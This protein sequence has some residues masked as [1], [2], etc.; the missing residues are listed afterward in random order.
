[1]N[2]RLVPLLWENTDTSR[3]NQYI[4]PEPGDEE[5]P[6]ALK[7]MARGEEGPA[8]LSFPQHNELHVIRHFTRLAG[9]NYSI[10]S[11]MYPLGSCTM[12][13]N[14]RINDAM[15]SRDEFAGIHPKNA[16]RA[17]GS[18]EILYNLQHLLQELSGFDAV[19]LN[20]AAGAQGELTGVMMI[21]KYHES[22]GDRA[23]RYVIV[24]DTAHGTNP[25]T[26]VM[27]GLEVK[28]VASDEAGQVDMEALKGMLGP[29]I[30]GM[31]LTNPN[32]LGI[33]EERVVEIC[34]LVHEAGGLM[35]G[36][37]ANFNAIA[38]IVKP[39]EL[40]FD[41]MHFNLHKTF[42]TPHGGGGPGAGPVG[43]SPELAEFLPGPLVGKSKEGS[44]DTFVPASSVGR[45][46]TGFGN[47]GILLRAYS[48]I[49]GHGRDGVTRNSEMAV[50]KANYLRHLLK[51]ILPA[52]HQTPSMHEFVATNPR[53][54]AVSTMDIAKGLLD[55]GFHSPTV[56]F[57]L[58]VKEAL[59]IE[60]T[61]SES[62]EEIE[63]FAQALR[64]VIAR[65]DEDPDYLHHAPYSTI[66][67]R[68][69]E[70]KANRKPVLSHKL[71]S[72]S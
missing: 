42:G 14:P 19:S 32:T 21:R 7:T 59:M 36:D 69:D 22:R 11:N 1:M 25:A 37:G 4:Y 50:L 56:Y 62:F 16:E 63:A 41:V 17:Q 68:L 61:E 31:M 9:L 33:F 20:P 10:D 45:M 27:C 35:Y 51:D 55:E 29:D 52:Y 18:L 26:V 12:K 38:G 23:R 49:A 30:A 57:P 28:T 6:E 34:S 70:V 58:T 53:K 47:F 5:M 46:K 2:D 43:C 15:A 54:D 24:P 60:P 64:R 44:F 72:E 40:G 39:A 65:A 13:Y 48:Y 66:L 67:G 71:S 8:A 3:V